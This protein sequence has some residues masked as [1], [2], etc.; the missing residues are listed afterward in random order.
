MHVAVVGAGPTG[1]YTA[2]VL[3]RRGHRVTVVDRD[4]GPAPDGTWDRRGVMQFRHPHGLRQQVADAL[5]AELPDVK[6][7]LLAAG[8]SLTMR[9]SQAVGLTCGRPLFERVLRAAAVREKGVTLVTGHADDVLPAAGRAAGLYVDG[10]PLA[11]DLVVNAS[12][13]AGRFA[14]TLRAPLT[15]SD[16]GVAY[17]AREYQLLPGAAPGPTSAAVGLISRF[18]GYIGV[19]FLQD[20][21]TVSVTFTHLTTDTGL[22]AVRHPAAYEAVVRAIPG[23]AEWTDPA[24]TRPISRVLPGVRL[25][26]TYQ[27]QLDP[28]GRV[29]LPG[30]IHAGDAV[31][32]TNP[33][34]G[35]GI[36]T[37]LQQAR[38]LVEL[39]TEHPADLVSLSLAFDDW[40]TRRIR[41]WFDDHRA[42]DPDAV[43]QLA[44]HDIDLSRPLTSGHIAAAADADK[45]LLP[46]VL[47]FL[48]MTG[49]PSSLAAAEPRAREL[50]ESGWRPA[51]V[52]GPSRD[53]LLALLG[54]VHAAT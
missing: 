47:P 52:P 25:R 8:A 28:D 33:T 5:E 11:A 31:C 4:P 3:A 24:R 54:R 17:V 22:A 30:L 41:P 10:A 46:L 20:N 40:C 51:P 12:G 48:S 34:A 36:A 9:G 29:A 42:W 15:E 35:R 1:L 23:L 16:C 49:L 43:R 26:N 50:Y 53:D 19:V 32:T 37:S 21:R 38:R 27:G 2:M 7:A 45:S 18:D 14:D 6:D 39:L 44:G 13:R